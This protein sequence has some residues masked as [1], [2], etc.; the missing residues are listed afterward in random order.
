MTELLTDMEANHPILRSTPDSYP[1]T[2]PTQFLFELLLHHF[3]TITTIVHHPGASVEQLWAC[4]RSR[5]FSIQ[6]NLRELP[7]QKAHLSYSLIGDGSGTAAPQSP[8]MFDL[9]R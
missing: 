5:S 9:T 8:H 2:T 6:E 7:C 1:I 4:L 3:L